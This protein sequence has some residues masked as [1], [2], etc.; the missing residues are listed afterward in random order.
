M[1]ANQPHI[2]F[3]RMSSS[4][5]IYLGRCVMPS[6]PR[7]PLGAM[8]VRTTLAAAGVGRDFVFLQ[9]ELFHRRSRVLRQCLCDLEGEAFRRSFSSKGSSPTCGFCFLRRAEP[10]LAS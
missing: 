5:T 3:P 4:V 7:S 2:A 9:Y 10:S 8:M 1:M 6:E